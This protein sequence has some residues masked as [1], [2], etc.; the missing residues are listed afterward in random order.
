MRTSLAVVVYTVMIV[1]L[2]V[3]NGKSPS[4]WK[5][6]VVYQVCPSCKSATVSRSTVS[7]VPGMVHVHLSRLASQ[8][9]LI[10]HSHNLKYVNLIELSFLGSIRLCKHV[11]N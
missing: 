2:P 8:I 9:N 5:S 4:E 3:G 1:G 6:R 11:K 7:G 10:K